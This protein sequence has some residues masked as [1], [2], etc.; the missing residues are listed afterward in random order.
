MAIG[1]FKAGEVVRI[2]LAVTLDGKALAVAN[3]RVHRLILP[4]RTDAPGYPTAMIRAEDGVYYLERQLFV[5]GNYTAIMRCEFDGST[6]EGI[7]SFNVQQ[8]FGFPRIERA[9]D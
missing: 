3:A 6:L 9:C 2:P 8:P 7:E 1:P 4:D 5:I